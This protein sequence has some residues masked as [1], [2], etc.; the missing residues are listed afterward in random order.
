[1]KK[2]YFSSHANAYATFRPTYPNELY[3]FIF[4]NV[5]KSDRAWDCGTGNGQTAQIL[6]RQFAIVDA[7][8]ISQQQLNEAIQLPNINYLVCP[9][10]KTPYEDHCFDLITVSQAIHWFQFDLFYDEVKRVMK[11]DGI[12][13]VW[14]YSLITINKPIDALLNDFYTN[15]VGS[16]WDAARKFV[17]SH[18]KTIPFPF[19]EIKAPEFEMK[20]NWTFDQ[21]IGYVNTWSAVKQYIKINQVNP[22]E[23][24]SKK[25][26]PLWF[27]EVEVRFPLFVRVGTHR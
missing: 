26:R 22:V 8:D 1:M 25:I 12:I 6:A 4:S 2:D 23:A 27:R 13:A 10:E 18:Y 15:V 5:K 9:A 7:T 17:D 21:L 14:G 3:D 20:F 16:Y 11:P 19:T 24:L